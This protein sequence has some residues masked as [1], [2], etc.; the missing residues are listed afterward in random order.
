MRGTASR[1]VTGLY[2][3]PLS[4]PGSL[5]VLLSATAS[6]FRGSVM[7]YIAHGTIEYRG[8]ILGLRVGRG[9]IQP[10]VNGEW[11]TTVTGII[12]VGTW[13]PIGTEWVLPAQLSDLLRSQSGLVAQIYLHYLQSEPPDDITDVLTGAKAFED[14]LR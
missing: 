10:I 2:P 11:M 4:V 3:C 13:M 5:P 8:E 9:H 12:Y 1:N 7:K 14:A 6:R